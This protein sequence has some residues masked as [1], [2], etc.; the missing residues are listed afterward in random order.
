M[1]RYKGNH[2][3]A[4]REAIVEKASAMIRKNGL[5]AT[6][7]TPVMSAVGLTHGGFYAHFVNKDALLEAAMTNAIAPSHLRLGMLKSLA[8]E[9]GDVGL[10]AQRYLS[11]P[12]VAD[13]ENGCAAAALSSELHRATLAVRTAFGDGALASAKVLDDI[14]PSIE[15]GGWALYATLV[16]ALS[17][18]RA[19]PDPAQQ[20]AVRIGVINLF[21]ANGLALPCPLLGKETK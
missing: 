21:Q 13:I 1:T 20:D 11:A 2:K 12:R 5:D 8:M 15:N 10:I 9:S 3:S 14:N 16:G 17:I 19:L 6:A 4:T 18:I 7:V